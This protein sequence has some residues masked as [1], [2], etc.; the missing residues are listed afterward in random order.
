MK[1]NDLQNDIIYLERFVNNGSPSGYSIRRTTSKDTNP[2]RGAEYINPYI[3]YADKS[4]F[5]DFGVIPNIYTCPDS[6][7]WVLVHPDMA[8]RPIFTNS[9]LCLKTAENIKLVPMASARTLM[10]IESDYHGYF[11]LHYDGTIG[12]LKRKLQYK[13]AMSGYEISKIIESLIDSGKLDKRLTLLPEIGARVL[14]VND[15]EWGMLWRDAKPYGDCSGV[16]YIVPLFSLFSKDRYNPQ[17]LTLLEQIIT[18][19]FYD[20]TT[21]VIDY[22]INPIIECYFSLL[23]NAGI[24][25]EWHAQNLLIG[26]DENFYPQKIIARDLESMDKDL[27]LIEWYGLP[28]QFKSKPFKCIDSSRE[29][30]QKKHSFMFDFKLGEYVIQPLLLF[31]QSRYFISSDTLIPSIKDCSKNQIKDLPDGFFPKQWYGYKN[32][33]IDRST[34]KRPYLIFDNPKFRP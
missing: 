27:T 14:K 19:K 11:K 23:K 28:Y 13:E 24:Q 7:S 22:L 25:G 16:K 17:D 32:V 31:L 20:P 30:Y 9:N 33:E 6:E 21:Y 10:L 3:C 12:R 1:L 2:F 15:Q 5:I 29:D 34:M 26:F 8:L 4:Y 18:E